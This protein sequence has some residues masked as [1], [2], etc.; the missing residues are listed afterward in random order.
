MNR[1]GIV[2]LVTG[3]NKGIGFEIVRQLGRAGQTVYLGARNRA[4]GEEAAATLRAEDLDVRFIELDLDRPE[5]IDAAAER[6]RAESGRL[7]VLV[8]NAGI[9]DPGDGPPS[10][11]QASAAQRVMNI[12]FFGTLAVI[13]AALPL[14]KSAPAAR[15]VNLSSGL[16]SLAWNS[17]PNWAFAPY[18]LLGYNTSKAAVNMLTVQLA[19]ELRDTAIKV[20]AANPGFTAT[21]MNGHQGTQTIEE[22]AAEPVRL[23]LLG[24]DGPTGGF[25]DT[26]GPNPW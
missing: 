20:N 1:S 9:V 8:N 23:A 16:G 13:Q 5:T 19:Y 17:D 14:L 21:D 26:S 24:P 18:K 15:I 7:D 10:T 4:L 22:G 25:F 11:V 3:A 12:N 2:A 6:I